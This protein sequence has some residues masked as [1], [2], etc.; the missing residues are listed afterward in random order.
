MAE[1][2]MNK[3]IH[4]AFRR[5]LDRFVAALAAFPAGDK[6]R[7]EQLGLAWDNFDDQLMHHHTSEH[8]IAWPALEAMGVSRGLI[9]EMDAE[10]DTMATALGTTRSAMSALR[11]SA[12][13]EDAVAAHSAMLEL[14][15]VTVVHLDHE[16]DEIESVYLANEGTDEMKAMGRK[17]SKVSPARGGR[18]FA[19]VLD[20]ATPAE[21]AAVT[22]TIPGP[23]L[24][25]INGIFGASYRRTVAPTWRS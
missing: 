9:T 8:A 5:D 4:G 20:G 12:S 6:K 24:L 19:W 1:M 25:I 21:T 10:H 15:R 2:S 22:G 16:E 7:A 18:F 23:V 3:A 13:A 17:F 11:A 14:R